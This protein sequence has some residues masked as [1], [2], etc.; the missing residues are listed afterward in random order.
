MGT[1]LTPWLLR[2]SCRASPIIRFS[3]TLSTPIRRYSK[4]QSGAGGHRVDIEKARTTAEEF[5]K[6][7]EEK[8]RQG[9]ASHTSEKAGD[10]AEEAVAGEATVDRVKER[11]MEPPGKGNFDKPK[12]D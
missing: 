7:A 12:D 10:A 5:E 2:S 3:A 9:F 1:H 6:V 8:A 11:Y 4:K